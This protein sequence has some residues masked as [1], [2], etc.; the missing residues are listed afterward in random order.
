MGFLRRRIKSLF[1]LV[2]FAVGLIISFIVINSPRDTSGLFR[3]PKFAVIDDHGRQ[4]TSAA[5]TNKYVLVHFFSTQNEIEMLRRIYFEWESNLV[6]F[7]VIRKKP[8]PYFSKIDAENENFLVISAGAGPI[9]TAFSNPVNGSFFVY[10]LSGSLARKGTSNDDIEIVLK[11][12]FNQLIKGKHFSLSELLGQEGNI[13]NLD[14]FGQV[15][16]TIKNE[17]KE[18]Y[19]IALFNDICQGCGSGSIIRVLNR[20][21]REM[22]GRVGVLCFV[23]DSFSRTD[24]LSLKSQLEID[25]QVSIANEL[26]MRKW[27]SLALE[28][29]SPELNNLVFI[30]NSRGYI[31]KSIEPNCNECAQSI[32]SFFGEY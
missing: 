3:L 9:I 17:K 22:K 1:S 4:L 19:L 7:I 28:Y 29:S 25:Y 21:Y 6:V 32:Y 18:Y 23:D 26:L 24:I 31:E 8:N 11:Q 15:H 27:R 13:L 10:D 12:T 20:V 30:I 2:V 14:Y 5:L 16:D